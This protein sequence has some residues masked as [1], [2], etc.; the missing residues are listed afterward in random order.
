M[1]LLIASGLSPMLFLIFY[2]VVFIYRPLFFVQD[3]MPTEFVLYMI[4]VDVLAL[5]MFFWGCLY[6]KRHSLN[7]VGESVL[8]ASKYRINWRGHAFILFL[9]MLIFFYLIFK[10]FGN[11]DISNVYLKNHEFYSQAKV[12]TSW[13]FFFLYAFVLVVLYE[14]YLNGFTGYT[15]FVAL[16]LILINAAT[17]GRGHV[18]TY[19]FLFLI[20]Y[21]VVWP[22]K[23]VFLM[24]VVV[25]V[26]I[27][28]SFAYNTLFRSGAS[29]VSSYMESSSSVADMNQAN[30]IS[31]AIDY[32]YSEGACYTC[33]IEDS[34][35]LF[36]PRRF[37][38]DK[39]ISNAE[40][41]AVYP[42]VAERGTTQ[43]FGIYGGTLINTGLLALMLIPMFY[44][45]YSY[46]YVKALYAKKRNY[47]NFILIYCGVN[48]VQ[49]VRGGVLDARLIRLLITLLLSYVL[50]RGVLYL[51]GVRRKVHAPKKVCSDA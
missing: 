37:F 17:G 50:Y 3:G 15:I 42:E 36:I 5:I 6:F 12:G 30:A 34:Y 18:I 33:F 27:V 49:F 4:F 51:F 45:L 14:A 21:A 29:N 20:I 28:S 22:G 48:A 13:L 9:T 10:V 2:D 1:R 23:K 40:T 7:G 41:R 44:M 19:F 24:G 8:K 47:L 11:F 31:A 35:N 43:T 38:P 39:P 16:A 32:W 26:L 25:V 46:S